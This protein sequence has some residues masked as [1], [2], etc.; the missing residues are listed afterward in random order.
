M[1]S[2]LGVSG[3][4]WLM[5]RWECC[6]LFVF[7]SQVSHIQSLD[8]N[9]VL[10]LPLLL[11]F[12]PNALM[13]HL[14]VVL[15]VFHRILLKNLVTQYMSHLL[16]WKSVE[17][18]LKMVWWILGCFIVVSVKRVS[19]GWQSGLGSGLMPGVVAIG[20]CAFL[21]LNFENGKGVFDHRLVFWARGIALRYRGFDRASDWL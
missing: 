16:P 17:V 3:V 14:I 19:L 11:H 10:F 6:F 4:S 21:F 1:A 5:E 8:R 9:L 12:V 20:F 18:D 13:L 2:F 7:F 15:W